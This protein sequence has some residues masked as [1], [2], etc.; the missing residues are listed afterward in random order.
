MSP[1]CPLYIHV[2]IVLEIAI[3]LSK[4]QI[5]RHETIAQVSIKG[6]SNNV[7]RNHINPKRTHAITAL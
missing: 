2:F 4:Q 7:G 5:I 3:G 1:I 6:S